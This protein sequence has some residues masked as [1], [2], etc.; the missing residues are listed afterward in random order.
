MK[1]TE[2]SKFGL[3][4]SYRLK[5]DAFSDSDNFLIISKFP[6][7]DIDKLPIISE[8]PIYRLSII[9]HRYI[10]HPYL[11][12]IYKNWFGSD[13]QLVVRKHYSCGEEIPMF[14]ERLDRC[15]KGLDSIGEKPE[16]VFSFCTLPI[17]NRRRLITR[18]RA[19]GKK[20]SIFTLNEQS[21]R[22]TV[23]LSHNLIW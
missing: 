14:R 22:G 19:R 20:L 7:F 11:Q 10:V 21:C 4:F 12:L 15:Q 17:L 5:F 13:V 9:C 6:F 23:S 1:K 18:L 16:R 8:I 3:L 2:K